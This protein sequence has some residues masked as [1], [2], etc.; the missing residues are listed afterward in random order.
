MAASVIHKSPK[1]N[2]SKRS[3][4]VLAGIFEEY[5]YRESNREMARKNIS[6]ETSEN[7]CQLQRNIS[8]SRDL[9]FVCG[10]PPQQQRLR[11]SYREA[12]GYSIH[13]SHPAPRSRSSTQVPEQYINRYENKVSQTA[14]F[15]HDYF[16]DHHQHPTLMNSGTANI[17]RAPTVF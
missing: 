1:K 15:Y 4:N 16:S 3:H 17:S 11:L 5:I 13:C 12:E 14:G 2:V 9:T 8:E 6:Q 7:I 10:Q